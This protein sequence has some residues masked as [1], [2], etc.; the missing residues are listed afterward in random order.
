ML[1]RSLGCSELEANTFRNAYLGALP[2][3]GELQMAT[4]NRFRR[5][6]MIRTLGGR[7]YPCEPAKGG[8]SFEYKSLNLL[9]QGS[10]ADQTK[11][12]IINYCSRNSQTS[13][14]LSQVYDELNVSVPDELAHE[15]CYELA[16]SM[17][18]AMELD[19]PVEV[20]VEAGPN[21][22]DLSP[23]EMPR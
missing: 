19:V 2:G 14:L 22:G 17:K 9:I 8:R 7:M 5:N 18:H 10:A 4:R 15:Q 23:V 3:V 21:W 1:F 12:A 11:Q 16:R 6:D 20:D 13:Y